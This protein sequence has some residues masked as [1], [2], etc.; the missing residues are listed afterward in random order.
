MHK[1]KRFVQLAIFLLVGITFVGA[2]ERFSEDLFKALKYRNIGPFRGGR[3]AASTGVP[4]NKLLAYFGGTGGG[5]WRTKNGGQTWDNISDGYFGGSIGAVTVSEWDPNVI[6]VGG[7]EVTVRGNV[8][9]GNGVWKSTDAGKT[10]KHVGLK[11]SR[12]IPRIRVHPRNP[13]LVYVAALG[14]LFGPNEERGVFRSKDGGETWEKVLYINDEVGACDLILDPNNPRIIFATTWRIKRTP[15]SLE[16]GGEGSGMWKSTD[17]G[18]TWTEITRN[19]GLPEGMMGI[20]GVTI[21]PLNSNRMWTLIENQK[22]GL[23]RSDD[24]GETWIKTSSDN[25]LRQRAWYYTRIY[26]DTENEDLV[27]VLN[28]SFWR[29]KDGGKTFSRIRTPH[30]DHHDLWIDPMDAKHLII[31]DD[32]GGQVSFDAGATWSTYHNQPTAQFYRVDVDNQFPYRVYAGQQDNSTVSIASRTMGGSITERDFHAVGG[33]ESAHVAPHPNNPNIVYAGSY[34]G[35]LTRY[36][37][38]T[39]ERRNITVYPDNPMGHGVKD[40]KYR[41]QWNFPIEFDPFDSDVLYVGSQHLHRSMDEGESWEVISPDLSTNTVSMQDESGGP[42][43]KDDTGVEY[44]CTVFVITPS[45]HEKGIIWI[46]TDDGRVHITKNGGKLWTDIT[47]KN[48][49]KWGMVNSIDQS[50]HDPA[51][52]YMAMSRYKSDDFKPYLF[53]TNNYGKSWKMISKGIPNDAF[54]RVVREDPG[55]KGL[56]YAGT[57]TGIYISF[58]DG[59][60]WQSF[61]LN[62]PIVP[63]TDLA[64]KE[65]DLV[66]GTQGRSFW[67]MD[68]LTPL[69]QLSDTIASANSHLY[70]P[71]DTYR[72]P[73]GGGWGG[74]SP[75]WGANPP[76]G[77]MTFYYFD[78][79]VEKDGEFKLEFMEADGDVIKTFTHKK[80]KK[81]PGPVADVKKGMNRFV[82]DM[83]YPDAK[84]VPGAV[85]WGGSHIG[86]KAV[87]GDYKV[88]MT[89]NDKSQT[90]SFKIL[91]DPRIN[92]TQSDFQDQFD[93]LMDIRNQT[94]EINEKILTIRSIKKQVNTLTGLMKDSG[95]KNEKVTSAGTAL[96]KSLAEIEEELIQVKSKSGQ[97]PLNY[98]I[99]LDNKIAALV[100]VVSSVDARPTTQSYDVLTDLVDQAEVHY[101]KLEKV[102]TDDLF[103]FN[104]MVSDE[105]VPAVMVIPSEMSVER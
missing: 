83:R 59:K 57:E 7:G 22:G 82:W 58:D 71:R 61:Q 65:N 101:K 86:P 84:K 74:P 66:V 68:D 46:G 67:I 81:N 105:G 88:R 35:F 6:Y 60:N 10:W 102:L 20:I 24:G 99:K 95:F 41:F 63:I 53:K 49:P 32:G 79:E 45:T 29:S 72:L 18:D 100:R 19:K 34:S 3:S 4:G 42:I 30:G 70:R 11:D 76:N 43:T 104:N 93:L 50:P 94:T 36:D 14:H 38:T 64:V 31:A 69:H 9:H 12:R 77:V 17:G 52:A 51:T 8:S 78:E 16:S 75:T 91:K 97:D 33:G 21:S 73:G 37:H 80:D 23:F 13:D 89:V 47:P 39:G 62:L 5:V 48:M 98:P 26:A 85:M 1:R 96:V 92:T 90:Q 15:Y 25:N 40:M 54:T 55:R 103:K 2:K 27:Y 56:L 44:Y 28:V 87:P